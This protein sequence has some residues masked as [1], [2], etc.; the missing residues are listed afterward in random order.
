MDGELSHID[1][2]LPLLAIQSGASARTISPLQTGTTDRYY[3]YCDERD[4]HEGAGI[5][6]Q[7]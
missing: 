7:S 1:G 5:A 6:I 2:Q 4:V 3:H